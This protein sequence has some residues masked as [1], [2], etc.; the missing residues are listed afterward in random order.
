V[1]FTLEECSALDL[2]VWQATVVLMATVVV[3]QAPVEGLLVVFQ[4]RLVHRVFL[5]QVFADLQAFL[6][7]HRGM[8]S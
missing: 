6:P 1:S 5:F 4:A 7:A 8:F 2:G 3:Q